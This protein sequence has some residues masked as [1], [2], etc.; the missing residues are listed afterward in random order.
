MWNWCF[1]VVPIDHPISGD[2]GKKIVWLRVGSIMGARPVGTS[3]DNGNTSKQGRRSNE[4]FHRISKISWMSF[5]I[6]FPRGDESYYIV[7]IGFRHLSKFHRVQGLWYIKC[8]TPVGVLS[9]SIFKYL[10]ASNNIS[11]SFNVQ[12]KFAIWSH[13]GG[14]RAQRSRVIFVLLFFTIATISGVKLDIP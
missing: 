9:K 10:S 7:R 2:S 4:S 13:N 14:V 5:W 8:T 3:G 12:F 11:L 6:F 1:P